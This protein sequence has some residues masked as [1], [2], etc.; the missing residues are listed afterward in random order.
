MQSHARKLLKFFTIFIFGLLAIIAACQSTQTPSVPSP[1]PTASPT[2]TITVTPSPSPTPTRTPMMVAPSYN[3][4][5]P[6]GALV[7]LGKGSVNCFALSPDD[8]HLAVGGPGGVYFYDAKTLAEIWR[9]PHPA[10]SLDFS[11]DSSM[12]A[13]G[14]E[15]SVIVFDTTNGE[16]LF[17]LQEK[18]VNAIETVAFSP[19]GSTLA[20][21]D[22]QG[23]HISY[24][25]IW[26]LKNHN[27]L[28]TKYEYPESNWQISIQFTPDGTGLFIEGMYRISALDFP[29]TS[30]EN[31]LEDIY[32][33]DNHTICCGEGALVTI[34]SFAISPNGKTLAVGWMSGTS[35][36]P[37]TLV[38][39]ETREVRCETRLNEIGG[40]GGAYLAFS[41]DGKFIAE[42]AS[43]GAANRIYF[44]N[45]QS[46]EEVYSQSLP[47]GELTESGLPLFVEHGLVFSTNGDTIIA[48][49]DDSFIAFLDVQTGETTRI[50][51]DHNERRGEIAFSPDGTRLAALYPSQGVLL[52]D[53]ASMYPV[54]NPTW[55]ENIAI[56]NLTFSSDGRLFVQ[57]SESRNVISNWQVKNGILVPILSPLPNDELL[58]ASFEDNKI[59]I[60]DAA[61]KKTINILPYGCNGWTESDFS[62]DH[63]YLA[64]GCTDPITLWGVNTGELLRTYSYIKDWKINHIEIHE[65]AIVA[66]NVS[67]ES[68][69]ESVTVVWDFV[70][71]E[72]LHVLQGQREAIIDMAFSPDGTI[73]ATRSFDGTIVL[74]PIGEQ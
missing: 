54:G 16:E 52:W 56:K 39:I 27:R 73:L 2:A 47:V 28:L 12:L 4:F 65:K 7:T 71:G 3:G 62:P 43:G 67:E 5:T 58:I 15:E 19:D 74:W 29:L 13:I 8:Q 14:T 25:H 70:T 69:S 38:D 41:P 20:A 34:D 9:D 49:Q 30:S 31:P 1:S 23:D 44:S 46:C 37:L 55:N 72:I 51:T 35:T 53:I 32:I 10:Y 48:L 68:R 11:P 18:F 6:P 22:Y 50:L 59:F 17:A 33:N 66:A 63:A 61:T 64:V 40:T 21:G 57:G 60:L 42:R 36:P 26:D 45:A 24:I